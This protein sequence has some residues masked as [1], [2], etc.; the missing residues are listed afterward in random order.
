MSE[1]MA[2][3]QFYRAF[4]DLPADEPVVVDVGGR[5]PLHVKVKPSS[6]GE[7]SALLILFHGALARS[8]G[9][10]VP[11]FLNFR[12][13]VAAYSHQISIADPSVEPDNQVGVGWFAGSEHNPAQRLLP[14][15]FVGLAD[16]LKVERT[17]Y[18]GSSGGGF[19]ALY[20]SWHHPGSIV[21]A[22]VPQTN[23]WK[24]NESSMR[25]FL[26]DCWPMGLEHYASPPVLD[27]STIYSQS[28]PNTVIYVQSSM[29]ERHLFQHMLPFVS[30]IQPGDRDRVALKVSYWGRAGHTGAVP[31]GELDGWLKAA[32]SAPTA[33]AADIVTQYQRSG[34]ET[35]PMSDALMREHGAQPVRGNSNSRVADQQR[36]YQDLIW[37][38]LVAESEQSEEG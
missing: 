32:I 18:V 14:Q 1:V 15:F 5:D 37:S 24:Y 17:V 9:V 4:H 20:Y 36:R 33:A 27:L 6:S 26:R 34:I 19:G 13:E 23:A 31:P 30:S 35:T 12:R 28:V 10:A 3:D 8:K 38:D 7:D 2:S 25:F 16:A 22:S 29:D 11:S 21:C